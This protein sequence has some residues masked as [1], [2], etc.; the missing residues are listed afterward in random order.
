MKAVTNG[1][2]TKFNLHRYRW[3]V[4]ASL[5]L[6]YKDTLHACNL[7]S[8]KKCL[9]CKIKNSLQGEIRRHCSHLQ[10]TMPFYPCVLMLSSNLLSRTTE[11]SEEEECLCTERLHRHIKSSIDDVFE[12]DSWELL[13]FMYW[14]TPSSISSCLRSVLN[15]SRPLLLPTASLSC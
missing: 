7:L 6:L 14:V 3:I 12:L 8:S 13:P 2:Q 15:P 5:L 9:M 1:Q 4:G 11:D 10:Y